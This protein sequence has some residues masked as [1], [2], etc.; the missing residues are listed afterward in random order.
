MLLASGTV[1]V[2]V[3]GLLLTRSSRS[4]AGLAATALLAWLNLWWLLPVLGLAALDK[5]LQAPEAVQL[6]PES[7]RLL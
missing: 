7:W 6:R 3:L 4:L 2:P 1:I 5:V